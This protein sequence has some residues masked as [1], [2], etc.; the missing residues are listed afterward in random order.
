MEY[1]YKY[2]TAD[3]LTKEMFNFPARRQR[4]VKCKMSLIHSNAAGA[5]WNFIKQTMLWLCSVLSNANLMRI[6]LLTS[7]FWSG[8]WISLKED[9]SVIRERDI[10][11]DRRSRSKLLI[12]SENLFCAAPGIIALMFAEKQ[13]GGT[14]SV[15]D[16]TWNCMSLC[17]CSHKFCKNI[18]VSFDF[19]TTW[20]QGVFCVH[21]V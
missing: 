18:P 5:C 8:T 14:L 2:G 11:A 6:R 10:Q 7:P 9:A 16:T 12:A 19:I 1:I 20:N 17:N 3:T 21:P 4:V 13:K 15:C